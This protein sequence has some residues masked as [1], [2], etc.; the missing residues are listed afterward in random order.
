MNKKR[1]KQIEE[2]ALSVLKETGFYPE[3]LDNYSDFLPIDV[4]KVAK[5]K[6]IEV[7]GVDFTIG[8]SGVFLHDGEK[9]QIG[10][11]NNNKPNRQRFTIAHELGHYVLGHQRKG[12]FV[13]T[14]D[15]YFTILF[16]DE[17]SSTGE[18]LQ[19][20][21]ANAFAA[22]LLMPKEIIL[23][24]MKNIL[25]YC[26]FREEEND[27]VKELAKRFGVSIQAMSFRLSN[28]DLTW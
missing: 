3:P 6:N 27:V 10:Y 1:Q 2:L 19:E 13:D 20:R 12:V 11:S 5:K 7:L 28:L 21:E 17:N 24:I 4:E 8:V 14:P 18:F 9:A 15:K 25:D 26:D 22:A 16:R 23:E